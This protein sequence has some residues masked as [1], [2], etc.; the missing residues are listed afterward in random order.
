MQSVDVAI[1][2]G[3]MVGLAVACGLQGSGLRVAVLEQRE[4]QPLAADAAPALR[5]SAINAASEKLLTRLGVWSDI[6]AR[7]ASCYHGMEVWDKDSFGR[8]EFDDQSMGYSHLGHIVENAVIHYALWQKAQQSSDITLMA[9]AELQQVAW[10]E[11]EAFLTLKDGAM[12]TARLVIGA[13]GANSWLRNKA[14]IPLTFWD[15]R[16]HAL[17]ATIR[18]E[19][20]HGAVARQAFHG[21]GILAFLPLSD[22]HLCSIVWSLAPQEAERM[23]QA[24]DEQFNQALNIAFDNRLGLCRVESERQVF[25]LT[26][27][28]ARQFAAHRLALVGDAAHTIHPLAG[29][30]VNLGFMDAAELVDELKRLHRQGKDIGQYLYLRR[31]ERSR[32]HSAALMLAGMQGF[33]EL[34]AGTHPAKKLLRDM[35]LKLA[36]TLP[37]VKPQLLRQA[38]GLNDLPEW[39]R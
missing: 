19:D 5:V 14:D 35:G 8:I 38:M 30:G 28:Y 12:L 36:D 26:G 20:A 11:N 2:G 34:F 24:S 15:Y 23:Q 25:P 22:P 21:E 13:D 7:R 27:R 32:K 39:L 18:T 17:V 10:G 31:Y 6:V 37:G 3:G 4:P 29:Q 9:P 33:R 16:H 1:V